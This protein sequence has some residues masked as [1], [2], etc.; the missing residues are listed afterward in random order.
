MRQHTVDVCT[1]G[2]ILNFKFSDFNK[3]LAS[4]LKMIRIIIETCWKVF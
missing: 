1:W 3:E 4:S 2:T